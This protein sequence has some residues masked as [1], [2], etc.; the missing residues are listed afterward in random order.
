MTYETAHKHTHTQYII[1]SKQ[2]D[3]DQNQTDSIDQL[4]CSGEREKHSDGCHLT[5]AALPSA[6]QI[7]NA[8][9]MCLISERC[10]ALSGP[11]TPPSPGLTCSA[12]L[13][14]WMSASQKACEPHRC[15]L[16]PH[17]HAQEEASPTR[18]VFIFYRGGRAL[19][20]PLFPPPSRTPHGAFVPPLRAP[21]GAAGCGREVTA[22]PPSSK[23]RRCCP[24]F[25]PQCAAGGG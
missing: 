15:Q 9:S 25:E 10:A 20:A 24:V 8:T 17:V 13:F 4:V 5:T 21:A 7:I 1:V 6:A 18:T 22:A 11:Q 14:S 2:P 12:E 23:T 19:P 16:K 3:I